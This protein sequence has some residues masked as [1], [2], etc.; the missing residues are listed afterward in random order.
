MLAVLIVANLALAIANRIQFKKS[1]QKHTDQLTLLSRRMDTSDDQYAQ[2]KGQFEVTSQKLGLTQAELDRARRLAV[3]IQ[4]QQRQAVKTLNQAIQQKASAQDLN[5]LQTDANTKFGSLSGDIAGTQKDLQA[6]KEA[7]TGTKGELSGAIA[8]THDELVALAHRTDRD[9]FEFNLQRRHARQ[10]IG[11]IMVELLKTNQKRNLYTLNLY[12]DDKRTERKDNAL[13]Q[14]VFFYVRG[15]KSP[16][17][18]VVNK[19][20]KNRISG[21]VST[22]KGLFP[23]APTV[24]TSRPS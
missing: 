22:E 7:L 11:G 21:C 19:L 1:F 17:E 18:L 6:T 12:F 3:N 14:P 24:L 8:R 4:R 9:Y 16:L 15:A 23:K 13:D 2:L 20:G 5:K 10:K